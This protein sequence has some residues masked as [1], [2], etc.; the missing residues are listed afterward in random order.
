MDVL[1]KSDVVHWISMENQLFQFLVIHLWE[2]KLKNN[3][4]NLKN[5]KICKQIRKSGLSIKI[6]WVHRISIENPFFQFLYIFMGNI[7]KIQ[8]NSKHM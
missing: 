7:K 2:K 3:T 1:W 4:K 6:R 5:M 8:Q